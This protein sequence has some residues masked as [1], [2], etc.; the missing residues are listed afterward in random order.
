MS[1]EIE[2]T[3]KKTNNLAN[4]VC[5]AKLSSPSK[6][7]IIANT[8]YQVE[9]RKSQK[10]TDNLANTVWEKLKKG[11]LCKRGISSKNFIPKKK[12]NLSGHSRGFSLAL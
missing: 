7:D 1:S 9:L 4:T 2:E 3:S 5:Q 12:E 6:T 10:I 8:L 11:Y